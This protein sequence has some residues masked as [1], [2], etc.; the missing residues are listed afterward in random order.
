[1]LSIS[2]EAVESLIARGKRN[3][4]RLLAGQ[5]AELGLEE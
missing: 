3:L 1:V 5:K 2:V 4:A